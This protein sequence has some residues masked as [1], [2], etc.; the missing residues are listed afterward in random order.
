MYAEERLEQVEQIIEQLVSSEDQYSPL[1]TLLDSLPTLLKVDE[2]IASYKKK[3]KEL[4]EQ[5]KANKALIKKSNDNLSSYEA[6]AKSQLESATMRRD[7][8]NRTLATRLAAVQNS[9]TQMSLDNQLAVKSQEVHVK[10]ESNT[11]TQQVDSQLKGLISELNN[12]LEST[13]EDGKKFHL[14]LTEGA[15]KI[16]EEIKSFEDVNRIRIETMQKQGRGNDITKGYGKDNLRNWLFREISSRLDK[17]IENIRKTFDKKFKNLSL[18]YN[19]QLLSLRG[20]VEVMRDGLPKT[21]NSVS[22]SSKTEQYIDSSKKLITQLSAFY[23]QA[24]ESM[25]KLLQEHDSEIEKIRAKAED[26]KEFK[27]Q[28]AEFQIT[29]R[30]LKEIEDRIDADLYVIQDNLKKATMF[31]KEGGDGAE[32]VKEELQK[33]RRVQSSYELTKKSTR[34]KVKGLN[35]RTTAIEIKVV[36]I[37]KETGEEVKENEE[38]VVKVSVMSGEISHIEPSNV[39]TI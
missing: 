30:K 12:K 20:E 28:V 27:T 10:Q 25:D 18:L 38:M 37:G 5:L 8:D 14:R 32:K 23:S 19:Q 4:K 35:D 36:I 24:F 13:R 2:A 1:K 26:R 15:S 39:S 33:V 21:E 9:I 22:M 6:R 7:K 31:A 29:K 11:I 34:E 16:M 3:A 17:G